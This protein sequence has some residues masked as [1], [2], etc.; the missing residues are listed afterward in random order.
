V[1]RLS[2]VLVLLGAVLVSAACVRLGVWQVSRLHEKEA[3]NRQLRAALA[4][5]PIDLRS[6][7]AI[8]SSDT[9]ALRRGRVAARGR[10]DETR[11]FL[12]MGRAHEGEPGV[13]VVTPLLP[14]D[15]GPAVLVDR[16]WIPSIDGANAQ[17]ERFPAKGERTI[18]GLAEPL[19]RGVART[20]PAP[21]FRVEIDSLEVWSTPRL[22][23]DSIDARLPYP[24][25][26]YVLK[27]LPDRAD[28][29]EVAEAAKSSVFAGPLRWP[30]RP[31]DES[32]HRSYAGQWFA[33]ALITLVGS[34]VL[35]VRGRR[36]AAP[37]AGDA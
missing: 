4:S 18:V 30:V 26:A 9:D 36:K 23:A 21:Y 34:I 6:A 24:V 3:L 33:F 5:A 16:G 19:V 12:L 31:Y 2:P 17:P 15:G 22:D 29:I 32:V 10:Y 7:D 13:A 14:D 37:G 28:S 1:K 25:R 20:R 8:A 35:V 27:A 11:Q